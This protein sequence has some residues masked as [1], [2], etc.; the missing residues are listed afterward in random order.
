MRGGA[1]SKAIESD[2]RAIE[3]RRE[4]VAP[5]TSLV[6]SAG[7]QQGNAAR[8][9]M[10]TLARASLCGRVED[11]MQERVSHIVDKVRA[12]GWGPV[13]AKC[14]GVLACVIGLGLVGSGV[15]DRWIAIRPAKASGA[16]AGIAGALVP[17]A[18][19]SSA[20]ADP[21]TPASAP[22]V[23]SSAASPGCDLEGRVVLNTATIAELDK[24][25]GIGPSKAEKIVELRTKLG[26]FARLEDLYRIKG[27][28]RRFLERLRPH[29]WIDPPAGC[30]PPAHR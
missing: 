29:V 9:P 5:A 6:V 30:D 25:P 21:S 1:I 24:L 27:I 13:V 12:S 11:T 19:A 7:S 18:L 4:E 15:C 20:E 14:A 2:L 16:A 17:P 3:G 10:T 28:K 26:R 22:P 23:A 8:N